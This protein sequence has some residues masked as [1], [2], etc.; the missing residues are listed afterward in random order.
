MSVC[1]PNPYDFPLARL[2]AVWVQNRTENRLSYRTLCLATNQGEKKEFMHYDVHNLYA[3]TEAVATSKALA[4]IRKRRSL[5]LSRSSYVSSGR[6]TAHWTGDNTSKWSHLQRSVVQLLEFSLFGI[7]WVGADICGFQ[8][9]V[10]PELCLRWSQV[11]SFFCFGFCN[12]L[13]KKTFST[14]IAA[15][16]LLP[17]QSQSQRHSQ[18]G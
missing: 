2:K 9:N 5:I 8:D 10:T 14:K 4:N 16:R 18:Q 1:P 15:G 6:Y 13:T 12:M 11:R 3:L 17:L 7:P